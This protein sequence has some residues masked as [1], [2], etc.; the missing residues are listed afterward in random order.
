MEYVN[1]LSHI[2]DEDQRLERM[3]LQLPKPN[4]YIP[5]L[6]PTA[7]VSSTFYGGSCSSC[8]T[9][10]IKHS[11]NDFPRTF[12][13]G[14]E[15]CPVLVGLNQDCCPVV[16]VE[17]GTF[18]DLQLI[19]Q[20]QIRAGLK[21]QKGSIGVI[22][23]LTHLLRVGQVSYC[24]QL[25]SFTEWALSINLLILPSLPPFPVGISM[26]KL[27]SIKQLHTFLQVCHFGNSAGVKKAEYSLWQPL[28]STLKKHGVAEITIPSPPICVQEVGG[29]YAH[30]EGQLSGGCEG[31]WSFGL[32][33]DIEES[34]LLSLVQ[35]VAVA[36]TDLAPG[37][38]PI[39]LPSKSSICA[40][41]RAGPKRDINTG[42]VIYLLGSSIMQQTKPFLSD[43]CQ[44]KGIQIISNCKGG[45][46]LSYFWQQD[47]TFLAAGKEDD[48]LFVGCL[49]N[50]MLN[51][52][53]FWTDFLQNGQKVYHLQHPT[54]LT[55]L[56]MKKLI[57]DIN[58]LIIFLDQQFKG[59]VFLIGPFPRH[60][61]RCCGLQD[62]V[63]LDGENQPV[64]MTGYTNLLSQYLRSNL[65]FPERC[66][67]VDYRDIYGKSFDARCLTDG[68]HLA[69]TAYKICANFFLGAFQRR[70]R[71]STAAAVQT[72][73]EN[74]LADRGLIA[75][76]K[77]HK[78][79]EMENLIDQAFDLWG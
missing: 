8:D 78:I 62:H 43:L 16:R 50:S 25:K 37:S 45:N 46:Y 30:C 64:S 69:D 5:G 19:L 38:A 23:L 47:R 32:P 17:S 34:F 39:M 65:S 14:D 3:G 60:I 29:M 40:G 71:R 55:D 20:K 11:L 28:T 79:D 41:L 56:Q 48:I 21:I 35:H 77:N 66:E 15:L 57:D 10:G 9:K 6:S 67:F 22:L 4:F 12:L 61:T 49:G 52:H 53:S 75:K 68:V 76:P 72:S 63:V 1:K 58:I 18:T 59:R 70:P 54:I 26:D 42:K 36:H 74:F 51:K 33:R 13:L 31:E 2:F 27:V 24:S 44:A 7:K 73:F